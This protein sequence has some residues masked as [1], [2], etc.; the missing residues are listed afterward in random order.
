MYLTKSLEKMDVVYKFFVVLQS[1][2]VNKKINGRTLNLPGSTGL[3]VT[4][5][6]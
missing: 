5:R 4:H 2:Q 6:V 1:K 3:T